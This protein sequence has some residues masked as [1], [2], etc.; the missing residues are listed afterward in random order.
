MISVKDAQTRIMAAFAPLATETVALKDLCG[1]VAAADICAATDQ[2]PFA[3]SAMD[4]YAVRREDGEAPRKLIGSAPAGHPFGGSVGPNEAV[5]IFTGS[6]VPDGADAVVIQEQVD[7]L[8]GEVVFKAA[9]LTPGHIRPAGLDFHRG[10]VL[11]PAG[12]RIAARDLALLAAADITSAEVRRRPRVAFASIGDELSVTGAPRRPGGIVASTGYGLAAM[13]GEWGGEAIDLGILPDNASEIATIANADADLVVTLGGASVGDHDLVQQALGARDFQLNF[14]KVAMRPGKPLIFGR[15][16]NRPFIG[17]PGNP[18]AA[19][20]CALVF[21]KPA[22]ETM[23][24]LPPAEESASAQL[25][26][27]LPANDSR[28]A[29]LR[30]KLERQ[31]GALWVSAFDQQDSAMLSLLSK[32]DALI[33][34]PPDAPAMPTGSHVAILVLDDH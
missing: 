24:G 6:V 15:L 11:V 31:D 32:A 17:M 20:V 3:V 23:L 18:V 13:I 25:R 26:H 14:W 27:A 7:V 28:Q 8:G 29:Y 2:P 21:L 5:R 30:A 9:A 34:Q 4:G 12:R 1:R 19:L 16:G 22:I 33:I 10:D